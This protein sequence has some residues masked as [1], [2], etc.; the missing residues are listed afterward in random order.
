MV[1]TCNICCDETN[2][3]FV[4]CCYCHNES[5]VKCS[6][7]YILESQHDPNCMFCKKAW[8]HEFIYNKFPKTFVNKELKEKRENIL[9][10]REIA[11]LPATQPAVEREIYVET[12]QKVLNNLLLQQ[13]NLTQKIILAR[14]SISRGSSG[15]SSSSSQKFVRKCPK[16]NCKGFLNQKWTCSICDSVVCKHCNEFI[17]NEEHKCKP[18]NIATISLLNKDTKPCPSCGEMIFKI[19][20]CDQMYCVSC[21]TAF[22]WK[23][24]SIETG[25]I[26]NPHYFQWRQMNGN[27]ERQVGDY[28]CGGL[29]THIKLQKYDDIHKSVRFTSLYRMILHI[30]EVELRRIRPIEINNEQLRVDYMRNK[31]DEKTFKLKLQQQEKKRNKNLQLYQILR[32]VCDVISE[33][34]RQIHLHLETNPFVKHYENNLTF[35]NCWTQWD[36]ATKHVHLQYRRNNRDLTKWTTSYANNDVENF[37]TQIQNLIQYANQQFGDVGKRMNMKTYC[38]THCKLT[39]KYEIK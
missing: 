20:G 34:M 11:Q 25:T 17:T 21:H 28:E 18:E 6:K 37:G 9:F 26:H 30:Q 39:H 7:K 32:M 5:C 35:N 23:H 8:T 10:E 19:Q 38:I 12:Q 15:S 27:Q 4:K 36:T 24:G 29:P 1:N 33:Y 16:E 2:S 13:H 22:S 31:L 14:N 3:A